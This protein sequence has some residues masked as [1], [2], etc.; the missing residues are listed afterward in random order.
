MNCPDCGKAM[1]HGF[2]RAESF[3]GG[4]KWMPEKSTKSLGLESVVKPDAV[5][6]CFI[7]GERCPV[8]R[9]LVMRY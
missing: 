7:E 8:C 6:F 2:L 4:I 1:E 9:C 3:I 5:G